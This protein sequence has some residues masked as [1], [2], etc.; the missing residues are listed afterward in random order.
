VNKKKQKNFFVL[1]HGRDVANAH[2]PESKKFLRRGRPAAFFKKRLLHF[3]LMQGFFKE[4][5]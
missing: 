2:A 4:F 5:E 1:A 3:D